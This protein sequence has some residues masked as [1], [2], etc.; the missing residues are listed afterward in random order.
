MVV[1]GAAQ[2]GVIEQC[3]RRAVPAGGRFAREQRSD[4]L[5]VER[6]DLDG[7]GRDGF[8]ERGVD[9]AVKLQH[10]QTGPK[11]L[12][13]MRPAGEHGGNQPFGGGTDPGRPVLKALRRPRGIA[14]VGARHVIRVRA[15]APAH[16]APLV[17]ADTL[18][19]MKNLDHPRRGAHV[20]FG[21]DERVRD[22]L[23]KAVDLDVIVDV[24][25]RQPARLRS[26]PPFPAR[27]RSSAISTGPSENAPSLALVVRTR[28]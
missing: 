14:P 16:D 20:D 27:L 4:A 21:V 2:I 6:A 8:G 15:V 1:A 19:T 24:D 5:A 9:A 28:R 23:E 11:A 26:G 25:A 22:R 10:A 18:A 3:R 13:G 7:A 17:Q 12:F